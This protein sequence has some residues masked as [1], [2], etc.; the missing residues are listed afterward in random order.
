[1]LRV[2]VLMLCSGSSPKEARK[3]M[4]NDAES[5]V[6]NWTGYYEQWD[7]ILDEYDRWTVAVRRTPIS[8]TIWTDGERVVGEMVEP[9][10]D[11]QVPYVP[12][13]KCSKHAYSPKDRFLYVTLGWRFR[14]WKAIFKLPPTSLL[15]ITHSGNRVTIL[16]T[17]QGLAFTGYM[18]QN[19]VISAFDPTDQHQVIYHGLL[20]ESGDTIT[21]SY[22]VKGSSSMQYPE[23]RFVLHRSV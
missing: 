16:K 3:D 10:L 8:A 14:K 22:I 19:G 4:L 9:E 23:D 2:S 18:D 6:G 13:M 11:K 21:G 20:A 17:Y 12:F 1:M 15:E 7:V 5:L